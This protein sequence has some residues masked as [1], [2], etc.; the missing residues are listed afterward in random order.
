[1]SVQWRGTESRPVRDGLDRTDHLLIATGRGDATAFAELYDLTIGMVHAVVLRI[2]GD[3]A[4]AAEVT[5]A[6]ALELWRTAPGFDPERGSAR[7]W[8]LSTAG[9]RA[10]LHAFS[11]R[12]AGDVFAAVRCQRWAPHVRH[13][14]S[15]LR[16]ALPARTRPT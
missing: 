16:A 3:R 14:A 8:I 1:M 10:I 9:Y 6:V 2:V 12:S 15:R 4:R 13:A 11:E 7:S 5:Q